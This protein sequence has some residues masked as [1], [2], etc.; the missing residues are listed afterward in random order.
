[1]A[2][3]SDKRKIMNGKKFARVVFVAGVFVSLLGFAQGVFGETQTCVNEQSSVKTG[4]FT[5]AVLF[6][7]TGGSNLASCE[8]RIYDTDD[9]TDDWRSIVGCSG[10]S[11]ALDIV[12][13]VRLDSLYGCITTGED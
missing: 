1:M 3:S 5:C 10:A 11:V 7:D 9:D 12:I 13:E 8:Y 4:D 6:A 2:G